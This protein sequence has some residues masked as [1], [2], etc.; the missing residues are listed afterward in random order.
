MTSIEACGASPL[1]LI[2]LKTSAPP[3][4]T[5]WTIDIGNSRGSLHDDD[6]LGIFSF[7]STYS[8]SWEAFSGLL[9]RKDRGA[10]V[11]GSADVPRV[12]GTFSVSLSTRS[13]FS[14]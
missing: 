4:S 7:S 14:C 1:R 5:V 8:T 3:S 2:I 10:T 13:F 6:R 9:Q 11:S 12:R